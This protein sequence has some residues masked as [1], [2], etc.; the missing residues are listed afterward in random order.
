MKPPDNHEDI[1]PGVPAGIGWT[2]GGARP[3]HISHGAPAAAIAAGGDLPVLLRVRDVARVLGLSARSAYRH[4]R[5]GACGTYTELGGVIRIR[6]DVF[7]RAME[8]TKSGSRRRKPL[9]K[10]TR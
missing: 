10:A 8:G 1:R 6:R 9:D 2:G 4:V 3:P 5:A 7:L